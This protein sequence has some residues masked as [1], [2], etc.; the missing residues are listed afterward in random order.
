[1]KAAITASGL[2]KVI[3]ETELE[4]YALSKWLDDNQQAATENILFV[5]GDAEFVG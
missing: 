1:M 5:Y 4:R 2:L 3:A